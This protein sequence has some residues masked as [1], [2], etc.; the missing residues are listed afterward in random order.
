MLASPDGAY[1]LRTLAREARASCWVYVPRLIDERS[2]AEVL[3][4]AP[5][6]SLERA[7]WRDAAVLSMLV[8]RFPGRPPGELL[9][10]EIEVRIDCAAGTAAIGAGAPFALAELASRLDAAWAGTSS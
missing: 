2:G 7:A 1:T 8:C 3:A 5:H 4:L 6:W 9:P 10:A